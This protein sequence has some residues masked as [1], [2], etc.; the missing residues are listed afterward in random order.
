MSRGQGVKVSINRH[1]YL[2]PLSLTMM[3][4]LNSYISKLGV[5][6]LTEK[7]KLFLYQKLLAHLEL[8]VVNTA[9]LYRAVASKA[10]LEVEKIESMEPDG[11]EVRSDL[12][13][14]LD[15]KLEQYALD[16][17][18]NTTEHRNSIN[19]TRYA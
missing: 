7:E 6:D 9:S 1:A 14:A 18:S 15:M 12:V 19:L 4:K 8:R 11:K 2:T 16:T 10:L 13:S 17:V 5:V 3:N